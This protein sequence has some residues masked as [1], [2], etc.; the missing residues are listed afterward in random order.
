MSGPATSRTAVLLSRDEIVG[1]RLARLA[2]Q[3][4]LSWV[5]PASADAVEVVVID[6]DPVDA[7]DQVRSAR[8]RWPAALL[9]GHVSAPDPE[10]W[11][12][13]Q[14]A[15]CDLVANRGALVA[16]MRAAL[17]QPTVGLRLHPVLPESDLAG[18]LGLVARVEDGP[19]GPV[20]VF[21]VDSAVHVVADRCPHA[22]ARVSDG[23]LE[24]V[25]L[26]CP[27]HG[28]QFDVSTGERLRGPADSGL[29]TYKVVIGQGQLAVVVDQGGRS[30]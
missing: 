27:R 16:R 19:T 9:A 26:T 4:G 30:G 25:V 15:G 3:I 13:A 14:R 11:L 20:A 10:R 7:L 21:C 8:A 28:S 2:E 6:L 5:D 12:A 22:G 17:E 29:E 1:R 18:R 23:P 24:G